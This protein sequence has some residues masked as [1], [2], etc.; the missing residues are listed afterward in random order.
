[1]RQVPRSSTKTRQRK[2]QNWSREKW[3]FE[4]RRGSTS[5]LEEIWVYRRRFLSKKRNLTKI[6][7]IFKHFSDYRR[8]FSPERPQP[9]PSERSD[10]SVGDKK[11][12]IPQRFERENAGAPTAVR[13][14]RAGQTRTVG[15]GDSRLH[16]RSD[17]RTPT[18]APASPRRLQTRESI[19]AG[20]EAH[21]PQARPPMLSFA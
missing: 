13:R 5:H 1:M 7:I 20:P 18:D 10:S 15:C 6:L 4:D 12:R 16:Q 17:Q 3:R 21:P 19:E 14:S 2:S 8:D 9:H 11:T